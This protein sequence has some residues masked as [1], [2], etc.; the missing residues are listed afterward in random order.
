MV[1][2]KIQ[3]VFGCAVGAALPQKPVDTNSGVKNIHNLTTANSLLPLCLSN[4][5]PVSLL[6]LYHLFTNSHVKT[7]YI[8][9]ICRPFRPEW[10]ATARVIYLLTALSLFFPFAAESGTMSRVA[11]KVLET[12][13]LLH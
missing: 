7:F 10:P 1:V 6:C 5:F 2:S 12:L 3:T 13:V 9:G 8:L 4:P 11:L